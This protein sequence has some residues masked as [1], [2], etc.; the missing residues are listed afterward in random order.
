[1]PHLTDKGRNEILHSARIVLDRARRRLDAKLSSLEQLQAE[2]ADD[3]ALIS[4]LEAAF[5]LIGIE[6]E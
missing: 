6:Q 2:I 5:D 1:M 3:R 4:T